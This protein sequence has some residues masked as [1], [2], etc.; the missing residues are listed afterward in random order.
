MMMM[1]MLVRKHGWLVVEGLVSFTVHQYSTS[2]VFRVGVCWW[3]WGWGWWDEK[4]HKCC[5][6]AIDG[7]ALAFSGEDFIYLLYV[8][9]RECSSP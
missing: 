5:F 6:F 7:L 8:M 9:V 4:V 1:M 2:V 3:C